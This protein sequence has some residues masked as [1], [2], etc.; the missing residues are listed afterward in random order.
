MV[1]WTFGL[2]CFIIEIKIIS[3]MVLTIADNDTYVSLESIPQD[4]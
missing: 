4:R 2:Y 3:V 1:L